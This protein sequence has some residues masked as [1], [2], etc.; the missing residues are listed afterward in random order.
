MLSIEVL[1]SYG[2]RRVVAWYT[3]VKDSYLC[4]TIV[5]EPSRPSILGFMSH[6]LETERLRPE[7]VGSM[8]Q[9]LSFQIAFAWDKRLL[10]HVSL[11]FPTWPL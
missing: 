3:V 5:G 8:S 2:L 4:P 11:F 6:D 7:F 9:T 1:T 10:R